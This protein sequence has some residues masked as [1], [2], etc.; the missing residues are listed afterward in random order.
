MIKNF[1]NND[2]CVKSVLFYTANGSAT[3]LIHIKIHLMY[4]ST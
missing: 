4:Y 3:D 2:D 1:K